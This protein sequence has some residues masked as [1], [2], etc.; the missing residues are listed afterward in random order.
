MAQ[1]QKI[2]NIKLALDK[3]RESGEVFLTTLSKEQLEKSGFDTS[4]FGDF[5]SVSIYLEYWDN[6]YVLKYVFNNDPANVYYKRPRDLG[7]QEY[8]FEAVI[9]YLSLVE[10]SDPRGEMPSVAVVSMEESHPLSPD[11]GSVFVYKITVHTIKGGMRMEVFYVAT[12]SDSVTEKVWG[13][14]QTPKLALQD[15]I[16]QYSSTGVSF[17]ENPF[18]RVYDEVYAEREDQEEGE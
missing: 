15:A 11:E 14:G 5:E 18:Q 8:V 4:T 6:E 7:G 17:D 1:N 13:A 10:D 2:Q 9:K 3:A 12:L 16:F